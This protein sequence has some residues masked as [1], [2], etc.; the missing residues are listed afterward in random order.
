MAKRSGAIIA[1][2]FAVASPKP[3][4][5]LQFEQSE[6][7]IKFSMKPFRKPKVNAGVTLLEVRD[8][9]ATMAPATDKRLQKLASKVGLACG[10][11]L[12]LGGLSGANW[13]LA[14]VEAELAPKITQEISRVIQRP[15]QLGAVERVSWNS[16]RLGRSVIPATA[17]DRDTLTVEA[18]EVQFNPLQ[19]VQHQKLG[20]TLTL[21]R[22][23]AYFDQSS[24]GKWLNLDLIFDEDAR[25]EIETVQLRDATVTLAPRQIVPQDSKKPLKHPWI[26]SDI[27]TRLTL[28]RVNGK[29]SLLNQGE[30]LVFQMAASPAGQG[31]VRLRGEADLKADQVQLVVQTQA[32]QL[33]P[34]SPFIPTDLKVDRGVLNANVKLQVQAHHP[35][36]VTGE[37]NLRDAALRAK[38]EPNPLTGINGKFR[39]TGQAAQLR[40]G[41]IQFGQIPFQLDGK[42]DFASGL[43]LKARIASVEAA[44]FMQTLKLE[45]PVPVQGALKSD[46]LR[47]TGPFDNP[48]LAG[49]AQMAKPIQFDRL[50][51]ADVQGSFSLAL[52]EDHL[53][54]PNLRL[55]PVVGGA[56]RAQVEGWL[57]ANDAQIKV[58]VSQL[59]ADKLARLYQL[60]SPKLGEFNA[61]TQVTI[62]DDQPS[63]VANW[64]LA[65]GRYPAQGKISLDQ[66][67]LRLQQAA[68]QVGEGRLTASA[69]LK[70]GRWQANLQ[71]HQVPLNQL[72]AN[73]PGQLQGRL[74]GQLQAEGS[75][76]TF[77]LETIQATGQANLQLGQ[78]DVAADLTAQQGAWQ[79]ELTARAVPLNAITANLPG[80]VG[81]RVGLSGRLADLTLAATQAEGSLQLSDG[82]GWLTTPIQSDFAW[83]GDRL[84]LK[85]A[86]TENI[87]VTGWLTPEIKGNQVSGIRDLDLDLNIKDYDLAALPITQSLPISTRGVINLQGKIKGTPDRP[88]IDS[89]IQ[90]QNLALQDFQFEPLQ[91]SLQT[92][93]N[94]QIA[95]DLQGQS[96]QLALTLGSDYRPSKFAVKLD[97]ATAQGQMQDDQILAQV[98]NFALEKLRFSPVAALGE[99][100]GLLA[101]DLTVDLSQPQPTASATLNVTQLGL[102]AI[103]ALPQTQHQTDRFNG[104]VHYQPNQIALRSGELHL[105]SSRYQLAGQLDPQTAAWQ[106]QI[107]VEQGQFQDLLTLLSPDDLQGLIQQ[108]GLAPSTAPTPA[109]TLPEELTSGG[110]TLPTPADLATLQGSFSG[111]ATLSSAP[112]GIQ[113]QLSLQGEN[114]RLANYGIGQF[115][116]TNAQFDGQTLTL[117]RVQASGFSLRLADNSQSFDGQFGF[118]GQIARDTL[119]G[120]LQLNSIALPQIQQALNLPVNMQGQVHANALLSGRPSQP[121]LIGELQLDQVNIQD[122]V[123]EATR[124]GFRYADQKFQLESWQPLPAPE[125]ATAP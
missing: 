108:I 10:G 103:N 90:V 60:D 18:I 123:I 56:I 14:R 107:A 37:A 40:Q 110:L 29:F 96:D 99:L 75:A 49:S 39:F 106:S 78:G 65:Q 23:T 20:L 89:Q 113:T 116:I 12:L 59:P 16:I 111:M 4:V 32:L 57:E 112:T 41:K 85:Q 100:R 125:T 91:G 31:W 98:R 53:L 6:E 121:S 24:K 3:A 97:Q 25:I 26:T 42:I 46:D 36:Q 67:V 61:Q 76:Q 69:E 109:S 68:V 35:P 1:E 17:S 66:D 120:Q 54:I 27:P 8:E 63:L 50:Q 80:E 114:W 117:P 52:A 122:R 43:D 74:Q 45:L 5:S 19:A 11:L 71:S 51:I 22:P 73:L 7:F 72:V 118:T 58:Q 13:S 77:S 119:Q 70:Q 48:V 93:P 81:G 84:Q 86:K 33:H 124:V 64:Q 38:G 62:V 87:A 88:Q 55:T 95:L 79:A 105:G 92:Q 28:Q 44:P 104:T 9:Q 21:I 83:T 94:R 30:R 101:A 47:L 15:I 2:L 115:S 82:L 34:L 102:G